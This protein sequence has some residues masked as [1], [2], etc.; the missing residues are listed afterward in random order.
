[1]VLDD[2]TLGDNASV[3]YN[4]ILRNGIN[5]IVIEEATS[6]SLGFPSL[7]GET[8]FNPIMLVLTRGATV[9]LLQLSENLSARDK[10]VISSAF[11]EL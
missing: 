11:T 10:L 2:V 1:M 3:W 5:R 8:G 4:A 9:S 7:G 6:K